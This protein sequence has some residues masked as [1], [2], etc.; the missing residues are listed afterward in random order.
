MPL[1]VFRI[2]CRF[3]NK[4]LFVSQLVQANFDRMLLHMELMRPLEVYIPNHHDIF[5]ALAEANEKGNPWMY[6][7]WL[8]ESLNKLLKGCCRNASQLTFEETVL[9][10]A[11]ELLKVES[12]CVRKRSHAD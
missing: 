4:A 5:H 9:A 6:G 1:R 12:Y 10:K 2:P 3:Y 7:A 11:S 8:D